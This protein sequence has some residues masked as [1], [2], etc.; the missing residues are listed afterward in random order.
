MAGDSSGS[1]GAVAASAGPPGA[2]IG[3]MMFDISGRGGSSGLTGAASSGPEA[4][5]RAS[6]ERPRR[7]QKHKHDRSSSSSS[8]SSSSDSPDDSSDLSDDDSGN[9]SSSS[10]TSEKRRRKKKGKK[11]K[12]SK[13][14]KRGRSRDRVGGSQN[15]KES[16]T[17]AVPLF[18]SIAQLPQWKIAFYTHVCAAAGRVDDGKVL[19]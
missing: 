9:S 7:K 8:S 4:E 15:T 5:H 14:A 10:S 16:A 3:P 12:K 13:K 2:G 11:G 17:V 1:T 18:P 6:F 19:K